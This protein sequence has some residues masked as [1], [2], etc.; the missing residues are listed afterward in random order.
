MR[1]TL[2]HLV[3]RFVGKLFLLALTVASGCNSMQAGTTATDPNEIG[4]NLSESAVESDTIAFSEIRG[5]D[6]ESMIFRMGTAVR[7]DEQPEYDHLQHVVQLTDS[8]FMQTTEV[9]QEQWVR[10]MGENPSLFNDARFCGEKAREWRDLRFCEGY[11]VERVS[12]DRLQI[13]IARI[14]RQEGLDT[15]FGRSL[16]PGYQY[17]LPTEAEWEY[18]ARGGIDSMELQYEFSFQNRE[19]AD[20]Y[21]WYKYHAKNTERRPRQVASLRPNPFGLHD[22]HG[23]VYEWTSDWAGDYWWPVDRLGQQLPVVNPANCRRQNERQDYKIA[24]GGAFDSELNETSSAYRHWFIRGHPTERPHL[25]FRLAQ[26]KKSPSAPTPGPAHEA[27]T[28]SM[29]C[30]AELLRRK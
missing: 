25:G 14:N 18:A 1:I 16:K 6:A 30:S 22:M 28:N 17:A 3:A 24:R 13:F 9:T 23:N 11:P 20:Q 26:I 19:D 4:S 7:R 2:T 5:K 15:L 29:P 21:V 10:I 27:A 8:Y 12:W